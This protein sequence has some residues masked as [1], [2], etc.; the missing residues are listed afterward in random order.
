MGGRTNLGALHVARNRDPIGIGELCLA[1]S[2]DND[3]LARM[4]YAGRSGFS[5]AAWLVAAVAL[6]TACGSSSD[7]QV[8]Q[9]DESASTT[10]SAGASNESGVRP[11][12]AGAG[13]SGTGIANNTI[14]TVTCAGSCAGQGEVVIGTGGLTAAPAG[15]SSSRAET[16]STT[17]DT[18]V[19]G[20]T[21]ARAS[22]GT[23][24][25][26]GA[27]GGNL[28]GG[29]AGATA[30]ASAVP[31]CPSCD[32]H[33]DCT[34]DL[35]DDR[36][37]CTHRAA[38]DET[39]CNDGN[40][41]TANDFCQQSMCKGTAIQSSS[42]IVGQL[43]SYGY[44]PGLQTL[45]AFPSEERA[46]FAQGRRLTLI[47]LEGDRASL[48]HDIA[49]GPTVTA[50]AIGAMV[51]V[52]RPRTFLIPML[53]HHLAIASVDRGIDLF[54]L[55]GD[56]LTPTERYGFGPGQWQIKAATGRGSRLYACT[57]HEL[58]AWSVDAA[59]SMIHRASELALP[60]QHACLGLSLSPDGATLYAATDSGLV[61]ID[62]SPTDGAMAV[63][64]SI[65]REGNLVADVDVSEDYVAIFEIRDPISGHGDVVVLSAQSL[66]VVTT[67]SADP[68]PG[69]ISATG[70]SLL[71][72]ERLL[73][74]LSS[75]DPSTDSYRSNAVTLQLRPDGSPTE[76][77]RIVTFDAHQSPYRAPSFHTVAK[78][79]RAALE[80]MHQLV[81]IDPSNGV[82]TTTT[83]P[84]QGSFERVRAGDDHTIHVYGPGSRH[85]VDIADP[86][87]PRLVAGGLLSPLTLEWL[88]FDFTN[89]A[90]AAMLSVDGDGKRFETPFASVMRVGSSGVADLF[91]SIAN[92]RASSTWH[93]S[94]ANFYE[95][96]PSGTD[97]FRIRRFATSSVVQASGQTVTPNLDQPL[98]TL[99]DTTLDRR[100]GA[101]FSV[102]AI[103]GD[104]AVL[105]QRSSSADNRIESIA[106][107]FSATSDG[108]ERRFSKSLGLGFPTSVA[109]SNGRLAAAISGGL[110]ICDADGNANH[111][112]F[113]E[114]SSFEVQDVL[115]LDGRSLVLAVAWGAPTSSAGVLILRPDDLVEVARYTTS[116]GV[117]SYAEID[118]HL[119]FGMPSTVA[120]ATTTCGGAQ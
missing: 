87:A 96:S 88:R 59:T 64:P 116:E 82:M 43:K 58:E 110:V 4:A 31:N 8:K 3:M 34:L 61:R 111:V 16:G 12:R 71:D 60:A 33:D 65:A 94:G 119:V 79:T 98:A 69:G 67:I 49:M 32:D 84:H 17:H 10:S 44:A 11:D 106:S 1:V 101:L 70:F 86:T 6:D 76:L 20:G 117:T 45:V 115:H 29:V 7:G 77:H 24:G 120:I 51:W 102:D 95:L 42:A 75:A 30:G 53:D 52:N 22:G 99:A 105:E 73:V 39:P 55:A 25:L 62:I 35:V 14:A 118:N 47:G 28:S 100:G 2:G 46:V 27:T 19:N 91:G 5:R 50:D 63:A 109:F 54:D 41:C 80:P 26:L 92:D 37:V 38:A 103:N 113:N 107:A 81:R 15:G 97:D 56:K 78:G 83:A 68:Q 36:C 90:S 21:S 57:A 18:A 112:T 104:V 13:A 72:G 23:T 40:V 108:F 93:A 48:L 114:S 74:Q 89:P 9:N 85:R 66:E